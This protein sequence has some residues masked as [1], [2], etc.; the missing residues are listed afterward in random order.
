LTE[1]RTNFKRL[2][3]EAVDE[4]LL[5][6]GKSGRN[7]VYFHLQSLYSLKKEDALEKPDVFVKSLRKIF[8]IGAGVIEKAIL[9]SLYDKLGLDYKENK[10]WDFAT[11]LNEAKN[12]VKKKPH[13]DCGSFRYKRNS[14]LN[15]LF[16]VFLP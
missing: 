1:N 16:I 2:L 13:G 5:V 4:G 7:A 9:K 3:F 15:S 8:G 14:L 12:A 11:Y 10:N 6:L